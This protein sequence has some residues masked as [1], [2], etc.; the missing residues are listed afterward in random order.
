MAFAKAFDAAE[1]SK[2]AGSATA[3][4]GVFN[5]AFDNEAL[6][7]L[8]RKFSVEVKD[9]G[10]VTNQ[11]GSGRCWMFA[12]LNVLRTIAMKK[13]GL[14]DLELSESYLMFYD[15]MEKSNKP[16]EESLGTSVP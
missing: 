10:S 7:G 2:L 16:R 12:G 11:K 1:T 4:N 13:L 15:Q 5:A 9:T 6:R 3:R 14:K 8:D